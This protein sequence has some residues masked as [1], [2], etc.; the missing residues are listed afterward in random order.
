MDNWLDKIS[1][2]IKKATDILFVMNP[3]GTSIGVVLGVVFYGL[4]QIFMPVLKTL[5]FIDA[6]QLKIYFL[7]PG[8]ILLANVPSMRHL[9]GLPEEMEDGLKLIKLAAKRGNLSLAQQRLMY[10]ALINKYLEEMKLNDRAREQM[11][12]I[13][14]VLATDFTPSEDEEKK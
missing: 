11:E 4:C 5:V 3:R 2:L 6:D 13:K 7:V 8:G 12:G 9:R 14:R 10:I 1:E